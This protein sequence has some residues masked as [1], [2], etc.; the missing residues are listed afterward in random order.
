MI[1]GK[2]IRDNE[3]TCID[4]ALNDIVVSRFGLS[5]VMTMEVF[6]NDELINTYNGDGMIVST[7]TGTTGY[8]LSAGGPIAKPDANFLVITPISLSLH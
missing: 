3:V 6:I 1:S 5:R 7:P 8:N 4:T 2:I